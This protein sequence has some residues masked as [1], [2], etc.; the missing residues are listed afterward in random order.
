MLI[1]YYQDGVAVPRSASPAMAILMGLNAIFAV[2]ILFA[3]TYISFFV[4]EPFS[5]ATWMPVNRGYG[6]LGALE[7]PF[8]ML[9]LLPIVGIFGGWVSLKSGQKT[10]AY[11][12]VAVPIVMIMLVMGWYYVTPADWR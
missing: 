8:L 1:S 4:A 3:W 12:F 11:A 9:W 2:G 5:W 6:L 7:Y 10:I